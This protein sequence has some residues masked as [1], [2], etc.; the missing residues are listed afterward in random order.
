MTIKTALRAI[1]ACRA[2]LTRQEVSTLRGQVLAGE[3]D[4]AMKG[5]EEIKRRRVKCLRSGRA[6]S[7]PRMIL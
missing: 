1:T 2:Y 4:A 6:T 3:I 5:L 7:V